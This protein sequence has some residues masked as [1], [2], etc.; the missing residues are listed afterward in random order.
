MKK[1][2][3]A[4]I[5]AV[6]LLFVLLLS[7]AAAFPVTAE[8]KEKTY[9]QKVGQSTVYIH[10]LADLLS[11]AEE[12]EL[13]DSVN[14]YC[15][16]MQYNILFLTTNYTSGKS[17]MVYS[18]DYM[19]KLFP[20]TD[21]NIAFV[22]DM[23]NRQIYINTMGSAIK[24]LSDKDIDKALDKAYPQIVNQD[25][26][27]TMQ[28]MSDY[29]LGKLSE[30][31]FSKFLKGTYKFSHIFISGV[32]TVIVGVSLV[33]MHASANKPQSAVTYVPKENY[34]VEDKEEN[35]IR[36][37]ETVES[38]Y[39]RKSSSSS[40]GGGSSHRSSS[41]RSHGGGGRSF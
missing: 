39:Y 21:E 14:K 38:G 40:G 29:C 19:D 12:K 16:K 9:H 7:V 2:F 10:D 30:T 11:N 20:D 8:A 24:I 34:N 15:K 13:L 25:Y 3:L 33:K 18:D 4:R 22:I 41:G 5:S 26:S 6:A 37:Y 27:A 1:Q 36:T 23:D 31:F 35:Y 32:I 28:E 17:T